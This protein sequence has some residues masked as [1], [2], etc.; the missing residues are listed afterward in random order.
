MDT[1]GYREVQ[2][3]PIFRI[4]TV[5][6][7]E[8]NSQMN[9]FRNI[10]KIPPYQQIVTPG[11]RLQTNPYSMNN[12]MSYSPQPVHSTASFLGQ[13]TNSYNPVRQQAVS[14]NSFNIIHNTSSTPL[15]ET[16]KVKLGI[17][18]N[19]IRNAE[20]ELDNMQK[21]CKKSNYSRLQDVKQYKTWRQS[22]LMQ[23]L[24]DF[25]MHLIFDP[26]HVPAC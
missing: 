22:Y 17:L 7:S 4:H 3:L 26:T 19:R 14:D 20:R 18:H 2:K 23:A 15:S 10:V 6:T 13:S 11:I 9:N 5:N 21:S 8:L 25:H 16:Q 12:Q 24:S 1:Q